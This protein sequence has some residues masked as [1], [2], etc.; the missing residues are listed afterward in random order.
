MSKLIILAFF[1]FFL[2]A[3]ATVD[4]TPA[5]SDYADAHN[6]CAAEAYNKSDGTY[7]LDR[8]FCD[9][10]VDLTNSEATAAIE[11]LTCG[12]NT[13]NEAD[14]T[15]PTGFNAAADDAEACSTA[16]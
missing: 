1:P 14:C 8:N 15:N 7:D 3:C 5:C 6:A 4:A 2:S 9:A 13:F 12:T 10:Y 16:E 11:V